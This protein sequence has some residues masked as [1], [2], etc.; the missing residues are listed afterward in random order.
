MPI[1]T[2]GLSDEQIL[3]AESVTRFVRENVTIE[4]QR[5]WWA[6]L[7][8]KDVWREITDRGWLGVRIAETLGGL[9]GSCLDEVIIAAGVGRALLPIAYTP[10]SIIAV[11]LLRNSDLA[12]EALSAVAAGNLRLTV[13]HAEVGM[14]LDGGPQTTTIFSHSGEHRITGEKSLVLGVDEANAMLVTACDSA[15]GSTVVAVVDC[16]AAGVD[17]S[18]V[19]LLDGRKACN[20]RLDVIIDPSS[21]ILRGAAAEQ[22]I[23]IANDTAALASAAEAVGAMR[24]ALDLT[25][26]HLATRR[27]FGRTL[28]DFQV[29]QHAFANM[30]AE[31]EMA[32]SAVMAATAVNND[33]VAFRK[34]ASV[35]KSK[36]ASAGQVIGENAVQMH[37][38]I[39]MTDE[40]AVG[41]FYKRLLVLQTL[42]GSREEHLDRLATIMQ[43]ERNAPHAATIR[44]F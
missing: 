44:A 33:P 3:L 9:N 17:R 19:T 2:I 30:V 38:G 1:D 32:E 5:R 20:I 4:R 26:T 14:A 34:L 29:L 24:G 35:A 43:M 40:Y 11:A 41:R 15:D 21:I 39:G 31:M 36:T 42:Y 12:N 7:G 23:A 22:S 28:A 10:I 8:A 25:R 6:G 13:A 18:E 37:G 16:S 27:Q